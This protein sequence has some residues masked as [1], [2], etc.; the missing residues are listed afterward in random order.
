MVNKSLKK[1]LTKLKGSQLNILYEVVPDKA[2]NESFK[3]FLTPRKGRINAIAED[4]LNTASETEQITVDQHHIQIYIWKG[5]PRKV[6]L[7]HGWESNTFRWK[8]L[9]EKLLKQDFTVI[10]LDA[11][12]HGNSD[13]EFSNVPVYGKAVVNLI[14]KHK[15]QFAVGHSLGGFTLL[16]QQYEGG[17]SSLKKMVLLAPAIEM[18]NIVKGFQN[19]LGLKQPLIEDFEKRFEKEYHYNLAEFSVLNLL[20]KSEIPTLFIH[21]RE[22]KIVSYKESESLVEQWD[23]AELMLTDGLRHSLRSEAVSDAVVEFLDKTD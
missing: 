18:E 21:D 19:T 20:E 4:F 13:G 8:A 2:V 15:I 12:A 3:L 17:I 9:I 22:D 14:E 11:P 1:F 5:G 10:S 16:F 23:N 6:L 7:V